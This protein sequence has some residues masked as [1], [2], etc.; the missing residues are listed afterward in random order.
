MQH[1]S[2]IDTL[3]DYLHSANIVRD[4]AYRAL[5][6]KG[7]IRYSN[8][9]VIPDFI[10]EL[11]ARLAAS[12]LENRRRTL[13]IF[14]DRLEQRGPLLFSTSLILD[15]LRRRQINDLSGTVLYFG[16][17]VG[18]RQH[19]DNVFIRNLCLGTVFPQSR[20]R[21]D[22]KL[23]KLTGRNAQQDENITLPNVIS[24]YSPAN[25]VEICEKYR[26]NWIAI[27]CSD[28]NTLSWLEPL[29]SH[30]ES[31]KLPVISW[32]RNPLSNLVDVFRQSR[33]NVVTWPRSSATPAIGTDLA[34]G[35]SRIFTIHDTPQAKPLIVECEGQSN[36]QELLLKVYTSLAKLT[37]SIN[38]SN[39]SVMR[40]ERASVQIAWK[41]LRT[42]EGLS[43]PLEIYESEA[44]SLWGISSVSSLIS[45]LTH[46][47]E[48]LQSL[49]STVYQPLTE[50]HSLL[51]QAHSYLQQNRPPIWKALIHLCIEQSSSVPRMIIFPSISGKTLFSLAMLS[52][53]NI[54]ED[55]LHDLNVRLISLK[56]LYFSLTDEDSQIGPLDESEYILTGIPSYYNT[57]FM[58]PLLLKSITVVLLGYQLSAFRRKLEAWGQRLYPDVD[59][60]TVNVANTLG[61]TH[62]FDKRNAES[63]TPSH[64]MVQP[65]SIVVKLD[66]ASQSFLT[67]SNHSYL[68]QKY[69][70]V[71][72]LSFLMQTD[73]AL[74][75]GSSF[76]TN[77]RD[78]SPT[79]RLVNKVWHVEFVDGRHILFGDDDRVNVV[80]KKNGETITDERFVSSLKAGDKILFISGQNRQSLFDLLVSRV[81]DNP[82]ISLHVKL[83]ERWQEDLVEAYYKR[84]RTE[85]NWSLDKLFGEMQLLGTTISDTQPLRNWLKGDTLR[86]KDVED[87]RRLAEIFDLEFVKQHY[88]RIHKAGSRLHGLHVSLSRRLNMWLHDESPD[89]YAETS[90][91]EDVIDEELG[92]TLRDFMNSLMILTVKQ[93]KLETGYFLSNT[94]GQL[95][96]IA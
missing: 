34:T 33:C 5:W 30:A 80:A 23:Q 54:T 72:E 20:I 28:K 71:E 22:L 39:S 52:Y 93:K 17:I 21:R 9:R 47:I 68:S 3:A 79:E 43:V 63:T 38:S 13:I 61:I 65:K 91:Y 55:D 37:K 35:L 40:L 89:L 66:E 10:D 46:Y 32:A 11:N 31:E 41:T 29:L 77:S 50:I 6:N 24:I 86:P 96:F 69:D 75:S 73:D 70:V 59:I 18:I 95:E 83:V 49:T 85:S 44:N 51:Q 48:N 90:D 78:S 60:H 8:A 62:T 42:M 88:K 26:P 64:R 67:S 57:I 16:A 4:A 84:K 56:N 58:E 15:F 94:L 82:A 1:Y 36:F 87:L 76:V 74:D 2:N 81:Y 92:L 27:D 45:T 7:A 19:L 14:P 12:T 25:P 53:H